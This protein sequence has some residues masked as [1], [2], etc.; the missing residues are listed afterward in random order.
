MPHHFKYFIEERIA[1]A[2]ERGLRC[3]ME[4][5]GITGSK[6][7][8]LNYDP[9]APKSSIDASQFA[10]DDPYVPSLPSLISD[11]RGSVTSILAKLESIDYKGISND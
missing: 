1:K 4:L 7:V 10:V 5:E 11:L 2:V 8:E 9:D 3:R 6:Y